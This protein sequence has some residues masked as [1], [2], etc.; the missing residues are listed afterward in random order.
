VFR[1]ARV[2]LAGLLA[3][4]LGIT[5]GLVTNVMRWLTGHKDLDPDP[6]HDG[7]KWRKDYG[8]K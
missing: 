4:A 6:W 1:S 8:G 7:I 3:L 5:I 2:L